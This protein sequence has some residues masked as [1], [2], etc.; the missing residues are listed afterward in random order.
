MKLVLIG[1]PGAGKGTQAKTISKHFDIAHI[2]TG[3][4]LRAETSAK[5]ELGLKI[6]D[7]MNSGALVSDEI[8]TTLLKNRIKQDDCKN[9]F[10]LDGY[11]RNLAQAEG[12]EDVVGKIDRVVLFSVDDD[13]IIERMSGRRACPKCG[14]MYHISNNPPKA[15]GVCDACGGELIQRKDDNADTVKHRLSVYHSTTAPLIKYYGDKGVLLEINGMGDI[16]EISSQVIK[17]LEEGNN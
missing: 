14:Q 2:S 8:V 13:A 16:N 5:T 1:A 6:I 11:P 4:L 7:I 17:A 15:E 10:I 9:G 3:D 12:L